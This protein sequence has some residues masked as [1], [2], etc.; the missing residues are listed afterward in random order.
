M[1]REYLS[2]ICRGKCNITQLQ[3]Q[4]QNKQNAQYSYSL[5]GIGAIVV[6]R[7]VDASFQLPIAQSDL[8]AL[9]SPY[10][11]LPVDTTA[12]NVV[13]H[14]SMTTT[15]Q[16]AVTLTN[17]EGVIQVAVT[18]DNM[19]KLTKDSSNPYKWNITDVSTAGPTW[20][21]FEWT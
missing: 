4:G 18:I 9:T 17:D 10:L 14:L 7:N 5:K 13:T 19:F 3:M 15:D 21:S 8:Y 1:N 6:E 16:A 20:K 2:E 12:A 11:L